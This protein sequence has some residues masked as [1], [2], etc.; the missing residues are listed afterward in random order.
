MRGGPQSRLA[1]GLAFAAA[2]LLGASLA[3][4][5]SSAKLQHHQRVLATRSHTALLGLYALDSRLALTRG[6]LVRIHALTARLRVEQKR[7]RLEL[8]I[9]ARSLRVSQRMLG[10]HLR[11]LYEEDEPNAIAILLGSSSLDAAVTRLNDLEQSANQG[12]NAVTDTENGKAKLARLADALAARIHDARALEARARQ[13]NDALTAARA[14]RVA[15]LASL[16]RQRRL[17][18]RQIATL[19]TRAQRV[20]Q[21]AQTVQ[22]HA[23]TSPAP[24]IVGAR[25][26][27][28]TSSHASPWF[29]DSSP[30]TFSRMKALGCRWSRKRATSRNKLPRAVFAPSW[31]H[32]DEKSW[33]GGPASRMSQGTSGYS[34]SRT[35]A[36]QTWWPRFAS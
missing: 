8:S 23:A 2:V 15:Y 9:V 27:C 6:E 20:V 10:N 17:T 11:T 30:W 36:V 4:A 12:A 25:S 3:G 13:T 31:F 14:Q 19:D 5:Q 34:T 26:A 29:A 22:A 33:H 18:K 32:S 7:V 24:V 21:Q 1:L 35:S 28:R 16:A